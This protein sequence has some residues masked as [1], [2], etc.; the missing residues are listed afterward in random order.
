VIAIAAGVGMAALSYAMLTRQAPQSIAPFF[1]SHAV[2]DG[3]GHNVVNVMLVDFRSLD[4]LGEIS[5]LGAVALAVYALLRGSVRRARA[6]GCRA[7]RACCRRI[8]RP[9]S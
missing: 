4:T 8:W 6:P 5:V 1:L 3:G 7:S 2:P 9:I